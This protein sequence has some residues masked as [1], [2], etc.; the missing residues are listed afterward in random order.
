MA[1]RSEVRGDLVSDEGAGGEVE[2][3]AGVPPFCLPVLTT[4]TMLTTSD[5]QQNAF[6]NSL[7]RDHRKHGSN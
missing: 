2:D 5:L 6:L 7:L 4:T 3:A 1:V